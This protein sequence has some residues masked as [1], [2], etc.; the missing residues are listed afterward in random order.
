MPTT[1]FKHENRKFLFDDDMWLNWILNVLGE[2]RF[3]IKIC[4]A[5]FKRFVFITPSVSKTQKS[6]DYYENTIYL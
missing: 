1:M 2:T 3:K 4:Y 6:I 5:K